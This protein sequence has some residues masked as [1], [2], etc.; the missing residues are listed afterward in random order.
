MD[1]R[2]PNET[3]LSS[4]TVWFRRCKRLRLIARPRGNGFY[5][6]AAREQ[7][8]FRDSYPFKKSPGD[9]RSRQNLG[10]ASSLEDQFLAADEIKHQRAF[11]TDAKASEKWKRNHFD[12]NSPDGVS[13]VSGR[14]RIQLR[15]D[16]VET[17]FHIPECDFFSELFAM[18]CASNPAD[19]FPRH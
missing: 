4:G 6:C 15:A 16:A 1:P 7:N 19:F 14:E 17:A 11:F 3:E 9:I 13:G 2:P 5:K 12:R 8:K 18:R 10:K